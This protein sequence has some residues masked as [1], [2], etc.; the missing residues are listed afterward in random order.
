MKCIECSPYRGERI[1]QVRVIRNQVKMN[2]RVNVLSVEVCSAHV[3]EEASHLVGRV[4][5]CAAPNYSLKLIHTLY[6]N[7]V[8]WSMTSGIGEKWN[9]WLNM[10][11]ALPNMMG[12]TGHGETLEI[13]NC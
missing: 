6:M 4:Y 1:I 7:Y 3:S 5:L 9:T 2:I 12:R 10:S 13:A 8:P 11:S